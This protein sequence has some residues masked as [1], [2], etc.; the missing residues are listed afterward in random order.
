[1]KQNKSDGK[2]G[3]MLIIGVTGGVGSGKSTVLAYLESEWHA[4]VVRLDDVGRMVQQSGG[5][6]FDEIVRRF[7]IE[8]LQSDGQIDR[9]KLGA[10]VFHDAERR[11]ELE[12][13]VHPVVWQW[14]LDDINKQ[15][16]KNC[17][18][19]VVESAV[20]HDSGFH[21]CCHVFFHIHAE[22]ETRMDRL[23]RS[24]GRSRDHWH[25]IMTVQSGQ[26]GGSGKGVVDALKLRENLREDGREDHYE[27][28]NSGDLSHTKEQIDKILM[29]IK[30][31]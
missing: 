21:R 27:I 26:V 18:L 2:D 23:I 28:D 4:H 22:R 9:A 3:N 31:V 12:E 7:G 8:I 1:M 24:R 16:K 13:I 25:R 14:L 11:R 10:I 20:L 5:D 29:N 6:C 17:S 30:G 19:Y 15:K